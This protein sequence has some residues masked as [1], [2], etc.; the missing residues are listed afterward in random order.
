[1]SAVLSIVGSAAGAATASDA[2]VQGVGAAAAQLECGA[3]T[4]SYVFSKA[5]ANDIATGG[6]ASAACAAI[7]T[8]GNVACGIGFASLIVTANAAKNRNECAKITWT[9]VPAPP[10]GTWWPSTDGSSRCR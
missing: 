9:K 2:D 7:P 1:M 6:A 10:L 4:C 3:L 5:V 8:P